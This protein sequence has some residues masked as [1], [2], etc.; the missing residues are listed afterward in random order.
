MAD[1]RMPGDQMPPLSAIRHDPTALPESIGRHGGVAIPAR[2]AGQGWLPL[3]VKS[4]NFTVMGRVLELT[5]AT[6]TFSLGG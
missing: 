5:A 2:A 6:P 3:S 4:T 1:D